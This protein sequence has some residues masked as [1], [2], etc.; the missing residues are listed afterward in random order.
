MTAKSEISGAPGPASGSPVSRPRSIN[1]AA[2]SLVVDSVFAGPFGDLADGGDLLLGDHRAALRMLGEQ[3]SD[4]DERNRH[5]QP[6]P[7]GR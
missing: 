5:A 1:V 7:P 6:R 3:L 2:V 4:R